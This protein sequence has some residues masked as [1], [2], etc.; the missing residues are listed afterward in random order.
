MIY[1][2]LFDMFSFI[3]RR[4]PLRGSSLT[5]LWW[6]LLFSLFLEIL[7]LHLLVSLYFYHY[8]LFNG[9]RDRLLIFWR[10]YLHRNKKAY[11]NIF[12]PLLLLKNDLYFIKM[13]LLNYNILVLSFFVHIIYV[14]LDRLCLEVRVNLFLFC[15][16]YITHFFKGVFNQKGRSPQRSNP[17][18]IWKL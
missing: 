2:S 8:Q 18:Y 15:F 5:V 10:N 3:V 13:V 12:L 7:L 1:N 6:R 14:L 17:N 11:E 9:V 16:T 4:Q